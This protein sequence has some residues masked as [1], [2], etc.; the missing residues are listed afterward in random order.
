VASRRSVREDTTRHQ[1]YSVVNENEDQ[2]QITS[3]DSRPIQDYDVPWDQRAR[4][5][6]RNFVMKGGQH[7]CDRGQDGNGGVPVIGRR[8]QMMMGK[9]FI[10]YIFLLVYCIII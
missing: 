10:P 1:A 8:E 2:H 6:E 3:F 4:D 5:L 7:G 9:L